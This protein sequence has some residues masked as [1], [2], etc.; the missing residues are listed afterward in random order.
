MRTKTVGEIMVPLDQYPHIPYWFTLR[1]AI[2]EIEKSQIDVGGRKSL[3]RICLVF[4][5]QYRLVGRVRRRD[6]LFGLEPQ[7]LRKKPVKFR[8]QLF[9][10]EIDPELTEFSYEEII[11]GMREQAERKIVDIMRTALGSVNYDDHITKAIY[12]IVENDLC[13][14]PVL[15]DGKV[16]G[17]VRTIELFQEIARIII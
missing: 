5:E 11:N 13:L 6:I 17:V 2:V 8:K 1:E 10:V 7:F 3:P 4:D 16:V 12:E 14:V 9:D 15:K